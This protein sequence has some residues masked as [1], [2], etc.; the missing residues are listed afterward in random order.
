[1]RRT[2]L[3]LIAFGLLSASEGLVP[4]PAELMGRFPIQRPDYDGIQHLIVLS[5]RWVVAVID[6]YEQMIAKV[7]GLSGGK[8]TEAIEGWRK[9]EAAGRP[10]WDHYHNRSRLMGQY[11]AQA[12]EAIGERN[13]DQP[14]HFIYSTG[15]GDTTA[16]GM[17][18]KRTARVI[19]C[20]DGDR[21]FGDSGQRYVH[22]C[23]L[24]LPEAM[25]PGQSC[26]L[27]TRDG[28]S[29]RWTFDLNATVCRSI[30]VNQV[31]Y[32]P[33]SPRK[34]AYLGAH[35]YRHGP[36]PADHA[37][38]FEVVDVETGKVVLSGQVV[39]RERNPRFG[40]TD[41]EPDP[42][43]RPLMYGEDVYELDFT[44][45]D[46]EGVFFLRVPG[47][48]RS[49][50]FRH[51]K[52]AYGEAFYV[53]A[54][55][56]LHQRASFALERPYTAWTRERHHLGP[57][58]ENQ[59]VTFPPHAESPKGYDR[60]DSIGASTDRSRSTSDVVGGW[61]DAA[62]W[63]R[64]LMHHSAVADMLRV[65][66]M[67]P[68]CFTDGQLNLPESGNGIPDL[69]DEAEFG[70][71]IWASSMDA[72]GGVSGSVETWTHPKIDD[73]Q[74]VYSFSRRTRWASLLFAAHAATYARLV[75]PFDAVGSD[76]YAALARRAYA[77]G[78]DPGKSLSQTEIPSRR[79]RGRGDPY[80]IA[81]TETDA[82]ID[83]YLIMAKGALY[84]LD[85]QAE[86]LVGIADL[87]RRA[88]KPLEHRFHYKDF[89][90][91]SYVDLIAAG[92]AIDGETRRFCLA[93]YQRVA[94]GYTAN[95]EVNAYRNTLPRQQDYW[96]GW[97]ASTVTNMNRSL[98]I[99][100]NLG[101]DRGALRAASIA[102]ADFMLG[103][104]PKGMAWT[105]G[106]GMVYPV[107]IQH[108]SSE[109]DGVLDPYPG[110]TVYG[111]IGGPSA[112][113]QFRSQTWN[114]QWRTEDQAVPFV[115]ATEQEAPTWRRYMAHP[116]V[117]VA[118]CEFT[119]HETMAGSLF[120]YAALLE[121][122]WM[123]SAELKARGP[124]EDSALFG[125]YHLP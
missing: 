32:L 89:S 2:F 30:K 70:L 9:S 107:V 106:L 118:Q 6:D 24:E 95:T 35:L 94:A 63:D 12:R 102:N 26:R 57:I 100:A 34:V 122:G 76:H 49:W 18:V 98:A 29:V 108:E 40:P 56:F 52:H 33:D 28:R 111:I 105:T 82:A 38:G 109:E 47:F 83:P 21:R 67:R 54:R 22:Y 96:L 58:Y 97:G 68:E 104:N 99:A 23:Y 75:R 86:V 119:V 73:P 61:Y 116:R 43:K 74:A 90:V 20:I 81:W 41:R 36:M 72:E 121:P 1:M 15:N 120:A 85:G 125:Y 77:F 7:D 88:H 53:A 5:D 103:A 87:V 51:G 66:E 25:Q 65:Y 114:C 91:W 59:D 55:G 11:M 48:G 14:D 123:P 117:N 19:S 69:L 45:L 79:Q 62:D 10:N 71:R 101:G 39:L 80:V 93:F 113:H 110:I 115:V 4:L 84:R 3:I 124:R 42:A 64:N 17:T 50:P 31:G 13:L 78:A 37:D 27:R 60:F 16:S 8:L 92:D 112:F 46:Q 44:A